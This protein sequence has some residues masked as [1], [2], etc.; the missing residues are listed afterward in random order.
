MSAIR[1][2]FQLVAGAVAVT[3]DPT[4]AAAPDAAVPAHALTAGPLPL[5]ATAVD[6]RG[7]VQYLSRKPGGVTINEAVD[8]VKKQVFDPRKVL[9]Y[10][11][12]GLV[13]RHGDRLK[14]SP[15]GHDL[16]RKLQPVAQVFRTLLDSQ[17]PYRAVLTWAAEQEMDVVVQADAAGFWQAHYPHALAAQDE[18]AIEASVVCFFQLCEAAALGTVVM[19]K[20]GQPTRLRVEREELL[21]YLATEPAP[22]RRATE[23][24]QT[25]L[26]EQSPSVAVER[27]AWRGGRA[28]HEDVLRVLISHGRDHTLSAQVRAALD[29]ADIESRAS[30]RSPTPRT[31]PD[32]ATLAALHECNAAVVIITRQDCQ[33]T[34][35]GKHV[36]RESLRSEVGALFTLYRGRVVCLWERGIVPPA[37]LQP[38]GA[39]TFEARAELAWADVLQLVREV[40]QFRTG[41]AH[42]PGA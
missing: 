27:R 20:K 28:A 8:A 15:L 19:G 41:A 34:E 35:T 18:R 22:E 2:Q 39:G 9:A 30:E 40:K 31:L 42:A 13:A 4:T 5:L 7:I 26:D 36:L 16:G 6:V 33:P 10:E 23:P 21:A 25:G 11:A 24:D 12:L 38:L 14:L 17:A 29:L 1:Q 37:E 3:P 32:A